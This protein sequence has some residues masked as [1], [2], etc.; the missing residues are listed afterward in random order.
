MVVR[1]PMPGVGLS[2]L[3]RALVSISVNMFETTQTIEYTWGGH[4]VLSPFNPSVASAEVAICYSNSLIKSV[5]IDVMLL[6]YSLGN[7]DSTFGK[8][9]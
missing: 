2:I 3:G 1:I 7:N 6:F 9:R 4:N 5:W 8:S